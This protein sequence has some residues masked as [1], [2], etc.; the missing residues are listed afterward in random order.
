LKPAGSAVRRAAIVLSCDSATPVESDGDQWIGGLKPAHAPSSHSG[1]TPAN[2][3]GAGAAVAVLDAAALLAAMFR[4]HAAS[5]LAETCKA[6]RAGPDHEKWAGSGRKKYGKARS[7]KMGKSGS[8][9]CQVREIERRTSARIA[10]TSAAVAA[11]S[12]SRRFWSVSSAEAWRL[13]T[14]RGAEGDGAAKSVVR[15]DTTSSSSSS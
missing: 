7:K 6:A 5:K 2:S 13:M 9:K 8:R 10:S 1:F 15:G 4:S 14:W 3:A 11:P 12:V